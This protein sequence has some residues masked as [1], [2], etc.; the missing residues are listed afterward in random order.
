[1]RAAGKVLPHG[2]YKK[3]ILLTINLL[4][5]Q[6]EMDLSASSGLHFLCGFLQSR[7]ICVILKKKLFGL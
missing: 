1:M 7:A 6:D 3:E 4:I 2:I 5:N